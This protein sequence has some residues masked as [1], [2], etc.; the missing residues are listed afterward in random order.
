VVAAVA[1]LASAAVGTVL[2][3]SRV[4]AD[5]LGPATTTLFAETFAGATTASPT[6][7]RPSPEGN[8][9]CLT[10]SEDW[11]QAPIPGC[12]GDAPGS[13]VL[14]LTSN[15]GGQVGTVFFDSSL[16]SAQGIDVSFDSYQW[17]G[18]WP[19][20]D[21]LS[22]ALAATDPG[23]PAAPE[24]AGPSGGALGYIGVPGAD[25]L[26]HGYLGV[27][28]D[29]YGAFS[30][31]DHAG[32]GQC[33]ANPS[34]PQ[35]VTVR[36]PGHGDA[37]YCILGTR[38]SSGA[39]DDMWNWS[40]PAPVP[41][42]VSVNPGATPATNR[43]GDEVPA[44]SWLV[45]WTSYGAGREVMTGA[46][47]GAAA[48]EAAQI[49]S[50][51]VDPE[52]GVP[53]QLSFGWSGSTGSLAENH[54]VGN[55]RA[56]TLTGLLPL[57]GVGVTDDG[58]GVV[59]PGSTTTV[60]VTPSLGAAGGDETRAPVVTATIPAGLTVGTPAAPGYDCTVAAQLV[61]C[62]ATGSGP[63]LAGS[64][65]PPISLPLTATGEASGTVTVIAK[66]SST[67]GNPAAARHDLVVRTAQE[68]TF[69]PLASPATIGTS[70]DLDVTG[71]GA[72]AP[73]TVAVGRSST[74][75]ACEV[76]G[77]VVRFTGAG[78]CVLTAT[79][80]GDAT[81]APAAPVSQTVV[82]EK[83]VTAVSVT[84]SGTATVRGEP[85][86]ATV[87]VADG[88]PGTVG[89]LVDGQAVGSPVSVGR[90]G[91]VTVPVTTAAGAAL[92]VGAHTVAAT[93]TPTDA[94]TYAG[95]TAAPQT[96][97]VAKALTTTS[98]SVAPSSITARVAVTAPGRADATGT[99]T[100]AVDGRA[101]GSAPVVGG[102]ATLAHR[103]PADKDR[104]VSAT[105]SGDGDL[106]GSSA[107][108]ARANPTITATVSSATPRSKAGWYRSAVTVSFRCT[109]AGAP[110]TTACPSPVTVS[111][112]G[113]AQSVTRTVSATDGGVA[114]A[115]V[116]GLSVDRTAPTARVTGVRAGGLYFAST[117][118]ARCSG[119]DAL[120]GVAT[121]RLTRTRS[122]STETLT[123][124]VT[125]RAGNAR[126]SS[127]KVTVTDVTIA[128]AAW[129]KG[130]WTVRQGRAYTLLAAGRVR[131]RYVDA[132]YAPRVPKG[133]D[134]WFVRTGKDRWAI[135][136][137]MG[138]TMR[139]GMW[140][141]GVR[142]GGQLT[143]LKVRVVR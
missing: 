41:V 93:F 45:A 16:P 8:T 138:P 120:S 29:V 81:R 53:Y 20:A 39:L 4:E 119:S 57:L 55:V 112:N 49:P 89:L 65:L 21:G 59:D 10:G 110:L 42:V 72:E 38:R 118:A 127:V 52:T 121:C 36:G 34:M 2:G 28:L 12:G 115:V 125:D 66:V 67:D 91:T 54:A 84:P 140:N 50:S 13:G 132:A 33:V 124:T 96:V 69:A 116:S 35:S 122:G 75:G 32:D 97:S 82:V 22:F 24:H 60:T 43:S 62:T 63:W 78:S 99:V 87:T 92:P 123:A 95:S 58:D 79:Q 85:V 51:W 71:G 37:G 47:P 7:F 94:A 86:T 106:L 109:T 31:G 40:R 64:D 77:D 114:T 19:P 135:G 14:R 113:A 126:S 104:R 74:D 105:Y 56:T 6:W 131:P 102:V 142:R 134:N 27:G 5:P 98:V 100:F 133:E 9:A 25:G 46:L 117:A 61:T 136:V 18:T 26:P 23:A 129:S 44:R 88:V 73:V 103:T 130:V 137:T 139:T 128:G 141:L 101:V 48:L 143:V 1:V 83:V 108:T 68:L 80:D 11:T 70:Q 30:Y 76:D 15:G 107:S 90:E 17:A 111:R 3:A